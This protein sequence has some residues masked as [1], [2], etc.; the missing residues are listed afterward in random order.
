MNMQ[1]LWE[2]LYMSKVLEHLYMV[3]I[4]IIVASV[5]GIP[6]GIL[7]YF[8][9]K[10]KGYILG[11]IDIIQTIPA[12]AV[13]GIVMVFL[14]AGKTTTIVGLTFYS[15]LPIVNNTYVG[16]N[17][18]TPAIVEAAKGIG[19]NKSQRLRK[20]M[21]PLATPMIVAGIKIA[22]VTA[23]GT[24]VFAFYVGG[25]G[26]GS[27]LT[28]GIRIQQMSYIIKGMSAIIIM[29]LGLDKILSMVEDRIQRKYN[30]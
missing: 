8:N 17:N 23:V 9:P 10:L 13:L 20:V 26:L 29:A 6:L 4:T 11:F 25:G 22:L 21:L 1:E 7:A 27:V 12:L 2:T 24:A 18:I 28:K 15:L 3:F 5:I 16:L 14:G 30:D 19:M